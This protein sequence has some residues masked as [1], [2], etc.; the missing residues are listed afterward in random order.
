MESEV[1]RN[2]RGSHERLPA[3]D[4]SWA[5]ECLMKGH[6]DGNYSSSYSLHAT[7]IDHPSSESDAALNRHPY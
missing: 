5:L 6:I 7:L 3:H 1:H 4:T 2:V